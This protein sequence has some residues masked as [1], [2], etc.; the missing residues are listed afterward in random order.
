MRSKM[1]APDKI[2][3]FECPWAKVAVAAAQSPIR[4][5]LRV[6]LL[7]G[8]LFLFRTFIVI[9]MQAKKSKRLIG[10]RNMDSIKVGKLIDCI[11]KRPIFFHSKMLSRES[12]ERVD[13]LL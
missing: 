4:P 5:M 1:R 11:S 2:V 10:K 6:T 13:C 8:S 7:A 3:W 9:G 12:A